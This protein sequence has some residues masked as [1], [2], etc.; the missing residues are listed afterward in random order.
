[1]LR[2]AL[3]RVIPT[4]AILPLCLTGCMNLFAYTGAK[5]LQLLFPFQARDLTL[6]F[7]ASF[8]FSPAWI[9]VYIA[10]FVFWFYQYTTVARE[11]PEMA[12]RLAVSDAV[13]KLICF[14]FFII[15]PTTNVRPELHATGLIGFLVRFIWWI[16]TPTNLFPS[17]HCFVAWMGTRFLF[18][19]KKHKYKPLMCTLCTIGSLLVFLST[20]FTKQHVLLDVI[21]GVAV[22]EI[23]WLV[24]RFTSLPRRFQGLNERFMKTKLCSFL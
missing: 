15:L 18:E 20:M 1:M 5:L 13:A 19:T 23:G 22:A 8:P 7:D 4:Y 9:L 2:K 21:G 17:I 6:A 14:L 24:G 11:S 3:R 16:D 12:C 10:T